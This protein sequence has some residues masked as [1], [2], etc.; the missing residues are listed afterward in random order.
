MYDYEIII[1]AAFSSLCYLIWNV[2]LLICDLIAAKA[3]WNDLQ[4]AVQ[5]I[6]LDQVSLK[7]LIR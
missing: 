4:A 1:W 5:G 6:W 3:N 2:Y 7:G